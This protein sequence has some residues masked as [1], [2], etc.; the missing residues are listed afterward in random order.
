MKDFLSLTLAGDRPDRTEGWQAGLSW[1]W[2]DEGILQLTPLQPTTLALVLSTGVHGNETA[3][4]E[5]VD[6][7][8]NRLLSG[9]LPLA[10]R[11]LVI[12][13][14]PP[15][16]R[17]NRRYLDV[18]MN[19]L[20]GGRWQ[21]VADSAEARR[22]Q[23]L[24][25]AVEQFWQAGGPGETRWHLDMHTAIRGSL[26]PRFGVM[27]QRE[28]PWPEDFLRWLTAAGLEALV[29]HRAPGG[30]FTHFTSQHL[31]AA[32]C[33]LELGKALPFGANDLQQFAAA[34]AALSALLA[35]EAWPLAQGRPRRYHVAQQITRASGAFTLHMGPETQN[36]TAFAQGT[37][38]AEAGEQRWVVEH[39]RE[40]VLF[41]NPAVA[42]GLRAGL[43]LV[44]ENEGPADPS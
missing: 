28:G 11:L 8:L 14:N 4:V 34:H 9:E 33:T 41:P 5:I 13:G 32:S 23:G 22:A 36:F 35:G 1:R 16:L 3:P 39:P 6:Q 17:Q 31:Q 44:E 37:L 30:T 29:F 15:A 40:V 26:H 38:L 27:P 24:E 21:K 42:V 12:Y 25:Q 10:V 7:L 19:R 43:M 2:L 20:F 18:D